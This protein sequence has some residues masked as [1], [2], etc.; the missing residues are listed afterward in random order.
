MDTINQIH[1]SLLIKK[2][3]HENG[4]TLQQYADAVILGTHPTLNHEEFIYQFGAVPEHME[5]AAEWAL[6]KGFEIVDITAISSDISM[7][8]SPELINQTF[9]VVMKF[10]EEESRS[11]WTH[12]ND[13]V[14]PAE[15]TDIVEFVQGLDKS[16]CG[17]STLMSMTPEEV[18]ELRAAGGA[19]VGDGA[20]GTPYQVSFPNP[21]QLSYAYQFPSYSTD[22]TKN[23]YGQTIA[24]LQLGGGYTAQNMTSTFNTLSLP[25]PYNT[26]VSSDGGTNN[27]TKTESIEVM[28][29]LY[30]TGG[31]APGARLITYFSPNTFYNW[32]RC[33]NKVAADTT[34]CPKALS[35]SW[36]SAE[37]SWG[38]Y[39]S[40]M[41]SAL[42]TCATLGISCFAASGDW[43]PRGLSNSPQYTVSYPASSPY[44]VSSG[45][46]RVVLNGNTDDPT[47]WSVDSEIVWNQGTVA[48]GGGVSAYFSLPAYQAGAGFTST[49]YPGYVTASLPQ[50]GV[51]DVSSNAYV[52]GPFY[53]LDANYEVYASG[54]SAAAPLQAGLAARLNQLCP[55]TLG[56]PLTAWYNA[57]I[58]KPLGTVFRDI[59]SGNNAL[60][61]A[62]ENGYLST[63]GWDAC[64]GMG[65]LQ[66][67]SLYQLHNVGETY[68][69]T[70]YGW[71]PNKF[72]TA[73]S[74]PRILSRITSPTPPV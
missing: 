73:Q 61:G 37:S 22:Y 55:G 1:F 3:C 63:V 7:L 58:N 46:T 18:D 8:G 56:F 40:S 4:M 5:F 65:S 43:G 67:L 17:L 44:C 69:K 71:R 27:P 45:G 15:L 32:Y 31:A 47:A 54:T 41:E 53:N 35:M 39:R 60:T 28:L 36:C 24:I 33:V 52:L 66:G 62:G 34:W 23:G 2:D 9:G 49:T 57:F 48:T 42:Q 51:P 29:D 10:V 74:W 72:Q 70:K 14:I 16:G 6:S 38:F 64:T 30:M 50:R 68:P 59:T 26:W 21:V 19:A 12:D 25:V 13:I 11:Y 20:P